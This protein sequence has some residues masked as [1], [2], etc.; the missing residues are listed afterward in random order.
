M[1]L[2]TEEKETIISE[3]NKQN[4]SHEKTIR[5]LQESN[6]ELKAKLEQ[7]QVNRLFFIL[8]FSPIEE[9]EFNLGVIE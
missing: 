4:K 6:K 1:R 8:V 7:A 5:H 9:G 3:L 2:F